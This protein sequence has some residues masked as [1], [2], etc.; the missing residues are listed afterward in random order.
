[1]ANVTKGVARL[2]WH[3]AHSDCSYPDAANSDLC[4]EH[5]LKGR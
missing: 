1:M 3:P 4:L 5:E 2:M